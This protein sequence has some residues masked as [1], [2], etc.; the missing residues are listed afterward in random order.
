MCFQNFYI[1][2][3]FLCCFFI[4]FE[5]TLSR[6]WLWFLEKS[7]IW[8][9]GGCLEII[10]AHQES[11]MN[12]SGNPHFYSVTAISMI[13]HNFCKVRKNSTRGV[14]SLH[15]FSKISGGSEP[16]SAISF[17]ILLKCCV[18]TYWVQ[19]DRKK[20]VVCFLSNH[21]MSFEIRLEKRRDSL[22]NNNLLSSSGL[23][24]KGEISCEFDVFSKPKNVCPSTETNKKKSIV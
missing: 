5:L 9:D 14:Y 2:V 7:W 20:K 21:N 17:E 3:A 23:V 18:L 12:P 4:I 6:L 1:T 8:Q 16:F 13:R 11:K 15:K 22:E 24:L 19:L 10:K